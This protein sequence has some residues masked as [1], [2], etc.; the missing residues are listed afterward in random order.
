MAIYSLWMCLLSENWVND[1]QEQNSGDAIW[2]LKQTTSA[3]GHV[4]PWVFMATYGHGGTEARRARYGRAG[5][6][7]QVD[8]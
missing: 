5:D 2:P 3:L 6:V 1:T 4:A 7:M 8:S